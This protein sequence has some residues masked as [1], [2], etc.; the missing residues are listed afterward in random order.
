MSRW[1]PFGLVSLLVLRRRRR[2]ARMVS[3]LIVR[4]LLIILVVLSLSLL[5]FG[6]AR[7]RLVSREV[8]VLVWLLLVV[9]LRALV[10]ACLF[11]RLVWTRR[12][13]LMSL[14]VDVFSCKLECEGARITKKTIKVA[15]F[16]VGSGICASFVIKVT[17]KGT[18]FSADKFVT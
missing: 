17:F 9:R 6:S 15:T 4:V 18:S 11:R 12:L 10:V 13:L 3:G 1:H 8:L 14:T 5:M 16:V 2:V 7:L